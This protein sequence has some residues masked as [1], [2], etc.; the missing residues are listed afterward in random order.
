MYI[1]LVIRYV[2]LLRCPMQFVDCM[3]LG[4]SFGQLR[5]EFRAQAHLLTL[6]KHIP[7]QGFVYTAVA[8]RQGF[9]WSTVA[10]VT[11]G[12][13]EREAAEWKSSGGSRDCSRGPT[14]REM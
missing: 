14:T 8:R 11:E 6:T 1:Y 3:G 7:Q 12:A 4:F 10:A 9:G 2:L 5:Q 13:W